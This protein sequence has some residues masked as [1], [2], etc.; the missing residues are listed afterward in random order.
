M[1]FVLSNRWPCPKLSDYSRR[2]EG[3]KRPRG[4]QSALP[5]EPVSRKEIM[6]IQI[7]LAWSSECEKEL[8]E[9]GFKKTEVYTKIPPRGGKNSDEEKTLGDRE[10]FS[11]KCPPFQFVTTSWWGAGYD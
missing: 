1:I 5:G 11:M 9:T 7:A 3:R 6:G 8:I 10:F 2:R 4:Q